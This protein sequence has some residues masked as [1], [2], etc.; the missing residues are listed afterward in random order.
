MRLFLAGLALVLVAACSP[1]NT[2]TSANPS[3]SSEPGHGS[4]KPNP[5]HA[6]PSG[7]AHAEGCPGDFNL[8]RSVREFACDGVWVKPMPRRMVPQG[9][10]LGRESTVYLSGYLHAAPGNRPCQVLQAD[11]DTGRVVARVARI[12]GRVG[13]GET[14]FCRHGGGIG[15]NASGLWVA[16]TRRLWLLDPAA[17]EAGTD[18]VVRAWDLAAP[19][20]GSAM[21]VTPHRIGLAGFTKTL[22]GKLR[23]Y[24]VDTVLAGGVT[25][26]GTT[27][28]GSMVGPVAKRSTPSLIQGV[29][30]GPGGVWFSRSQT[31]CGV[32]S[33]PQGDLE[34]QPGA[35][36]IAFS[37]RHHVW[38]V[39][40]SGSNRFRRLGDRPVIPTLTRID[41]RTLGDSPG[42]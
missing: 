10:A 5:P 3:G 32:L 40:E 26:L 16:E 8:S 28:R 19:V 15:L 34:F 21:T 42:C 12:E 38:V 2:D 20:R 13:A 39:S 23:W 17:V 27:T 9:L 14:T 41:I 37:D 18:P 30:L 25:T 1:G 11:R 36:G 24:D 7:D 29:T 31:R 6:P 35:E 4:G 33:G 22:P